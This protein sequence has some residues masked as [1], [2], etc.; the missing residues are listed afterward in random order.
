VPEIVA[1]RVAEELAVEDPDRF[2]AYGRREPTHREHAGEIQLHSEPQPVV[3]IAT[4]ANHP[5]VSLVEMNEPLKL[6]HRRWLG[7]AAVRGDLR[8][9]QEVV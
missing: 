3:I 2:A 9:A 6:R 4:P 1:R 8:R 7:V 5:R